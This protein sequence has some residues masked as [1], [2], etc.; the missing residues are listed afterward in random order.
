MISEKGM[1]SGEVKVKIKLW[2]DH[3]L[4]SFLEDRHKPGSG[5]SFSRPN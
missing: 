1:S 3:L 2:A 4:G 5:R